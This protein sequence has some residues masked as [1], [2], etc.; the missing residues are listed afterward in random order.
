MPCARDKVRGSPSSE[1]AVTPRSA[2][3]RASCGSVSGASIPITVCPAW[4]LPG[5]GRVTVRMTSAVVYSSSGVVMVAPAVSYASS[6][7]QALSP[8]PLST[9]TS[10]PA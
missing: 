7:N 10:R 3:V 9:S 1:T 5:S 6:G 4:S 2:R 8:A